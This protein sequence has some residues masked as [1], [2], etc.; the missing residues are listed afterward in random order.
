M[1]QQIKDDLIFSWILCSNGLQASDKHVFAAVI[2]QQKVSRG[3]HYLRQHIYMEL[4]AHM[5]KQC[6]NMQSALKGALDSLNRDFGNLNPANHHILERI[7]LA[8][9][10]LDFKTSELFIASNGCCRW[11]QTLSHASEALMNDVFGIRHEQSVPFW[12]SL[13][14][15]MHWYKFQLVTAPFICTL[16]KLDCRIAARC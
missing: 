5:K 10:F 16:P 3:A 6:G 1:W 12:V 11:A 8:V 4:L 15:M 9:A 7:E 2:T 13:D 14:L